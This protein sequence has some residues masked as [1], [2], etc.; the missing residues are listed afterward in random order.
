[1]YRFLCFDNN[2]IVWSYHVLGYFKCYSSFHAFVC[3]VCIYELAYVLGVSSQNL[4]WSLIYIIVWRQGLLSKSRVC[5]YNYSSVVVW[6]RPPPPPP[7][8]HAPVAHVFW[9]PGPYVALLEVACHWGWTLRFWDP[10]ARRSLSPSLCLQLMDQEVKC[11]AT[12]LVPC[13]P[14][15]M[16]SAIGAMNS[17]S[18]TLKK[19]Q[20]KCFLC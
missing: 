3:A 15:A 8:A 16:L 12:A 17:P 13:L 4:P 5:Q 7:P 1:M 11:S 19:A 9:M 20:M 2:F 14:A 18:E 10:M 6:M